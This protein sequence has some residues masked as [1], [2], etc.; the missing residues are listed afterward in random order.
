MVIDF[1]LIAKCGID[2]QGKKGIEISDP[3]RGV[4]TD[5]QRIGKG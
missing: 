3:E 1:E 2:M 5:F 4:F